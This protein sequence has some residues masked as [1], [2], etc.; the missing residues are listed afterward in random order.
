MMK[1]RNIALAAIIG[2][3]L[4]GS[5]ANADTSKGQRLYLKKLKSKCG[6]NGAIFAAKHTQAEWEEA[7]ESGKLKDV[8]IE[9]CPGGKKFFDSPK[10]EKRYS[11]HLYDFVHDYASDSGNVPSC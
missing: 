10:F 6:F 8:M 4:L 9:V 5:A 7:K 11:E 2:L 3:G 1:Y